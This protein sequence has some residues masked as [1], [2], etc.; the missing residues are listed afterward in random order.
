MPEQP[1]PIM[2]AFRRFLRWRCGHAGSRSSSRWACSGRALRHALRA[3]AI[4]PVIRPARAAR[5]PAAARERVDLRDPRRLGRVWTSSSRTTRTSTTG[6]PMSGRAP[7][8]STC[9]SMS[10]SRTTFSPSSWLSPRGWQ[11]RER[12]KAKLEH[13][14]ATEFPERRRAG[15]SAGIGPA[16]RMAAAIP[17]ERTGA[18]PG[19]RDRVQGRAEHRGS[20]PGAEN[21]NYNWMEPARTIRIRV[22]QDQARLLGLSS[23]DLAQALNT[24]VS[25]VTATA[26]AQRDLSRRRAG[27]RLRR[28]AHVAVDDPD[29]SGAAAERADRSAEPDRLGRLR[30]GISHC[31]APGPAADGDGA[32]RCRA[33]HA[34]RDGRAGAGAEDRGAQC[35]PAERLPYRA[36]AER[37][38]R[39]TRRRRRSPPSCR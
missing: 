19:A 7:S 15:L 1:G 3:A 6:A 27:S 34:G 29:A 13:A 31:L 14:L 26:D 12:V 17:G 5:R 18:G 20:A 9:R 21:V 16:G 30:P 8:A 35:Q 25:G 10:S 39:A 2:R 24:V 37:S 4:L 28:A 38:R 23:Q 11:Q 36:S 22:D 33:R 32:G